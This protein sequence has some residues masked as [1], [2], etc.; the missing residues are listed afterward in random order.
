MH[1]VNSSFMI[2]WIDWIS[3]KNN[4]Y[5]QKSNDTTILVILLGATGKNIL[6]VC[7]LISTLLKNVDQMSSFT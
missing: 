4:K 2:K 1:S 6:Q 3:C 7:S 5:Q